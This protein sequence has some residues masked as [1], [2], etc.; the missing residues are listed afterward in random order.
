MSDLCGLD[1]LLVSVDSSSLTSL[2]Q[3]LQGSLQSGAFM[4]SSLHAKYDLT[5]SCICALCGVPDTQLHWLGCPR[6]GSVRSSIAAWQSHHSLDTTAL[7]AH[8]LPSRSPCAVQW[9][10][11]LMAIEDTQNTFLSRPGVGIQHVFTDGSALN[12]RLP[13][14][15]ASWGGLSAS[16]GQLVSIGYVPGLC[17]T[18]DR[19]ELC[20]VVSVVAWQ[21]CY[22]ADVH[23]WIDSKFVVESLLFLQQHTTIGDWAHR[24]LWH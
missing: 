16:T 8:L 17:Q 1:Q 7:K 18:N 6:F 9:K 3:S 24:D 19:A 20:A 4:D 5:K 10:R 23:L 21:N 11:A 2:Q 22:A 14:Q 12:P 13:F 15:L